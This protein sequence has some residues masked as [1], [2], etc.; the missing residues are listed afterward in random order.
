MQFIQQKDQNH[1]LKHSQEGRKEEVHRDNT[2]LV[3]FTTLPRASPNK[4][5]V[6]YQSLR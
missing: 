5:A 6:F 1:L 2:P 3:Y 4:C